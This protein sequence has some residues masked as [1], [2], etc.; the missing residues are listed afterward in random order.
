MDLWDRATFVLNYAFYKWSVRRL[1]KKAQLGEA[2]HTR[3]CW[4]SL[5]K[6]NEYPVGKKNKSWQNTW[7]RQTVA[8]TAPALQM[9][10]SAHDSEFLVLKCKSLVKAARNK[11]DNHLNGIRASPLQN[12]F[13]ALPPQ[14]RIRRPTV[15]HYCIHLNVCIWFTKVLTFS[16]RIIL[17]FKSQIDS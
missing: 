7:R 11:M 16:S 5:K 8:H 14:N 9:I 10:S 6:K 17:S 2:V 15:R 12:Q 13:R 4:W 1:V 3:K